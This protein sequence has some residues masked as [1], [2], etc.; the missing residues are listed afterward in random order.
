M[1]PRKNR[2]LTICPSKFIIVGLLLF[3]FCVILYMRE[4]ASTRQQ[5]YSTE[6]QNH[7]SHTTHQNNV[8][9]DLSGRGRILSMPTRIQTPAYSTTTSTYPQITQ[10]NDSTHSRGIPINIR[11]SGSYNNNYT[12]VG[13]LSNA[14]DA[15]I[16]LHGR[17]IMPNR[18]K[19]QYYTMSDRYHTIRLPITVGGKNASSEYGCD[20]V[21]NGDTVYVEGY[22][23]PFKVTLYERDHYQY[24]PYL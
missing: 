16:P 18:N 19:W 12:Q 3:V 20:E 10:T 2:C 22:N 17:M 8:E 14:K 1:A 23:V 4:M 13:F 15:I 9:Q 21:N 24:I 7:M 6:P 11:T 5:Y